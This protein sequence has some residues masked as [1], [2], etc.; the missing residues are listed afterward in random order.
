M[1]SKAENIG[2]IIQKFFEDIKE[3]LT[4]IE[5]NLSKKEFNKLKDFFEH[6]EEEKDYY[7]IIQEKQ[8]EKIGNFLNSKVT[9]KPPK[10]NSGIYFVISLEKDDITINRIKEKFGYKENDKYISIEEKRRF[11]HF[12]NLE[13]KLTTVMN[14]N[15]H[16]KILYIGK[17]DGKDNKLYNRIVK[18]Y[19][20]DKSSHSGGRAIWQIQGVED[21]YITWIP[22]DDA[23]LIEG[24]LIQAYSCLIKKNKEK[25][26]VKIEKSKILY[27]P[28]ANRKK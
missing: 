2:A 4:Y 22:I 8:S 21:F 11:K 18:Q 28:F 12:S 20:I 23:E 26:G 1:E 25:D 3:N 9:N 17:A 14:N 10:E 5:K 19:M 13:H 15:K 7:T 24:A 6:I 16:T 27:Y